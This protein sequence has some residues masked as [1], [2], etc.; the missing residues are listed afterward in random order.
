MQTKSFFEKSEFNQQAIQQNLKNVQ[1]KLDRM[2][3]KNTAQY[4]SLF[5]QQQKM[6]KQ[7]QEITSMIQTQNKYPQLAIALDL[8]KRVREGLKSKLTWNSVFNPK[9]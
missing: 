8:V 5:R 6:L 7:L 4:K 9:K 1:S 3:Q 2:D